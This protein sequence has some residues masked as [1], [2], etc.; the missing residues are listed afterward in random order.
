MWMLIRTCRRAATLTETGIAR[1]ESWRPYP[2][3][4]RR[5]LRCWRLTNNSSYRPDQFPVGGRVT[6]R[7]KLEKRPPQ[8]RSDGPHPSLA[9]V[10]APH[11]LCS[12]LHRF[13]DLRLHGPSLLVHSEPAIRFPAASLHRH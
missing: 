6:S 9:V 8:V 7:K 5:K 4:I 11:D 10:A 12:V 3:G 1:N 13:R 2:A